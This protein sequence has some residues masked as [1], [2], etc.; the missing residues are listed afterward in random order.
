M[1]IGLITGEFPP[2]PGGVGDFT[3]SLAEALRKRGHEIHI[4]SRQGFGQRNL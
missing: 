1:K 4:L 3:R 2:M